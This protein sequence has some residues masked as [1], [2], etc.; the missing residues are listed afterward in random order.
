MMWWG[1]A[2]LAVGMVSVAYSIHE[3]R[4]KPPPTGAD[5]LLNDAPPF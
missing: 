3:M 2:V 4:P 1:G 5:E